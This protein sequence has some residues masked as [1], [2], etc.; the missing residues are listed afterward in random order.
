MCV[1]VGHNCAKTAELMEMSS[2]GSVSFDS[3]GIVL[4]T[5][6]FAA[7][8][9]FIPHLAVHYHHQD[10]NCLAMVQPVAKLQ[11]L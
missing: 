1:F 4:C 9:S 2:H 8:G 5:T 3:W 6:Q 10:S 7:W 11:K